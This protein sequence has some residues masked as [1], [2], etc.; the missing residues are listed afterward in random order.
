MFERETTKRMHVERSHGRPISVTTI[1][2]RIERVERRPEDRAPLELE[3]LPPQ[4]VDV[5]LR[6]AC[7]LLPKREEA[8][9]VELPVWSRADVSRWREE[10]RAEQEALAAATMAL[11]PEPTHITLAGIARGIA[12]AAIAIP[13]IIAAEARR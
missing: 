4:E 9:A 6:L 11:E 1:P 13:M 7:A 2:A 3:P 12:R 8:E 10:R 5:S